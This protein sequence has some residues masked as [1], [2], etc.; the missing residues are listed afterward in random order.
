MRNAIPPRF[1]T[2]SAHPARDASF[3]ESAEPIEVRERKGS[4]MELGEGPPP[5]KD[6]VDPA[7]SPRDREFFLLPR[8]LFPLGTRGFFLFLLLSGGFLIGLRRD[9]L[10]VRVGELDPRLR[11]ERVENPLHEARAIHALRED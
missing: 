7:R 9:E 4:A 10:D 8:D 2:S 6:A 11:H 5:L 3:P 1:R